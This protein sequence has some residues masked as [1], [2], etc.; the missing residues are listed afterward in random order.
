[1]SEKN[2][3]IEIDRVR[4]KVVKLVKTMGISKTKLGE[5]LGGSSVDDPR[6]NINRASRF[7]SGAQKKISLQEINSLAHFF[8]K[9]VLWFLFDEEKMPALLTASDV[10]PTLTP[11]PLEEIRKNLERMGFDH[12]FIEAQIR[13]LRAMEAYNAFQKHE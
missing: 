13:Q 8:E 9:P 11:K 1:M 3:L 4:D 6:V 10:S 5:V 12:D 7:L 2:V